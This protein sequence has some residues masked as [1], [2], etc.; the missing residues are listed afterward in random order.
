MQGGW[1]GQVPLLE[2]SGLEIEFVPVTQNVHNRNTNRQHQPPTCSCATNFFLALSTL[3]S[4]TSWRAPDEKAVCRTESLFL[5]S[6][7][8]ATYFPGQWSTLL[9]H[10]FSLCSLRFNL[11]SRL[12]GLWMPE[13]WH[14]CHGMYQ[15]S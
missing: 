11:G 9:P 3:H 12:A 1:R 6:Q 2:D 8:H 5:L 4:S 14:S 10:Y 13:A 15:I 7:R